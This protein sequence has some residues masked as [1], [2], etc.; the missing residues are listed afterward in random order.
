MKRLLKT[1]LPASLRRLHTERKLS[2]YSQTAEFHRVGRDSAQSLIDSGLKPTDRVLEIGCGLGRVA[3]PLG[4]YLTSGTYDGIDILEGEIEWAKRHITSRFSTFRFHHADLYNRY[5]NVYAQTRA[6]DYRF[7][8]DSDSFDWIYLTSV[9]THLLRDDT[10]HY[11]S[12]IAR[13]LRPGARCFATFFLLTPERK[14]AGWLQRFPHESAGCRL[15]D[16]ERPEWEVAYEETDI[17][18]LFHQNHLAIDSI[19]LNN[20]GQDVVLATKT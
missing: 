5:Y 19:S 7:P 13:M 3:L 11:I 12:E 18:A 6:A 17:R 8:F 20:T 4:E 16:A 1:L 10:E 15:H 2:R 14:A 9:F